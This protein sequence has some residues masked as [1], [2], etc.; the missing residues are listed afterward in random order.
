MDEI[1]ISELLGEMRK[2]AK[3][4]LMVRHAERPKMDVNDPS[5]GDALPITAEGVR[6]A[7]RLGEILKELKDETQFVASPL[8]RTRMTAECIA[9]GMGLKGA[10]IPVDE[11]WGNGSFYYADPAEVLDVFRPANFF[12]ASREYFQTGEQR[13]FVNLYKA[14]DALEKWIDEHQAS[15]FFLIATHDLYIAAFLYARKAK[16][17]WARESWTRFLDG[18]AILD[19][20][21]GKRRYALVRTGLSDGIV[22]V[23]V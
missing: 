16:T 21:S 10:K 8:T 15:R 19:Y 4:A 7:K 22:G 1:T 18:G 20:P 6:T 2:G 11:L 5:F 17:D 9:E 23:K 14:S 13:G 12:P 3:C